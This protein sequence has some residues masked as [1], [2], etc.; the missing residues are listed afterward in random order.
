MLPGSISVSERDWEDGGMHWG[1]IH[2]KISCLNFLLPLP[3]VI[4]TQSCV[5]VRACFGVFAMLCHICSIL[6]CFSL[7]GL[8]LGRVLGLSLG[9]ETSPCA[10][11]CGWVVMVCTFTL[12]AELSKSLCS[13]H[14][15][16]ASLFGFPCQMFPIQSIL[17]SITTLKIDLGW[18]WI[19]QLFCWLLHKLVSFSLKPPAILD[20]CSLS[21]NNSNHLKVLFLSS[22][23]ALFLCPLRCLALK[24]MCWFWGKNLRNSWQG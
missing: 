14:T 6:L 21:K 7:L 3:P 11:E 18:K 4:L 16:W 10:Q 12:A 23:K 20:R 19:L 5:S 17:V 1:L 22:G 13:S 8:S 2:C 9:R 15:S 24:A